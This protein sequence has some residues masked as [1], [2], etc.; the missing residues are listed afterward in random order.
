[1]AGSW[2]HVVDDDGVYRGM[3][4][5]DDMGD[6]HEAIEEMAFMLMALRQALSAEIIQKASDRY[7]ECC[8]GEKP[9][10]GFWI[11]KSGR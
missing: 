10:P 2:S 11:D 4:L 8:R 6:A 3:D 9:W 7:Y 5:L 1:M